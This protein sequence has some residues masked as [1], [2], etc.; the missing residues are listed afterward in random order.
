MTLRTSLRPCLTLPLGL[1]LAAAVSLAPSTA[2]AQT[3]TETPGTGPLDYLPNGAASTTHPSGVGPTW[4]SFADCEDDVRIS[5]PLS[6]TVPAAGF[7]GYTLSAYA[8]TTNFIACSGN[9]CGALVNHSGVTGLCWEVALIAGSPATVTATPSAQ[10]NALVPVRD[11]LRDF[12]QQPGVGLGYAAGTEAA[13]HVVQQSGAVPVYLWFVVSSPGANEASAAS[14]GLSAELLGP[15]PPTITG[16]GVGEG[17]LKLTWDATSDPTTQGYNI[18]IDPL[19]GHEG[20][21]H[22]ASSTAADGGP[23]TVQV[24]T[25]GGIDG[26]SCHAVTAYDAG[27]A[28]ST[29]CPSTVLAGGVTGTLDAG[30]QDSDA[31]DGAA[32]VTTT[33]TGSPPTPAQ[34]DQI[35]LAVVGPS[36]GS[37]TITGLK[38]GT[39]YTVAITSV[40]NLGDNGPLSTP[41]CA[42]PSPV[43]DFYSQYAGEGGTAGG[44]YCSASGA[45]AG[46]GAAAWLLAVGACFVATRRRVSCPGSGSRPRDVRRDRGSRA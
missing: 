23:A 27:A 45:G 33:V 31:D 25:D 2:D 24:C 38:D 12:G 36:Q 20:E 7:G 17:L 43:E 21:A 18:F 39:V 10:I 42:A 37:A 30:V 1:A 15:A 8:T 5:V 14:V 22:D 6:V 28:P 34:I 13:C 29:T 46:A 41:V 26:G 16:I 40:D 3:V 32:A 19:P 11:L 44:G 35:G 9:D 4:I